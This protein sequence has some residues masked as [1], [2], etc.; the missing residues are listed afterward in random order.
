MVSP[1]GPEPSSSA[2]ILQGGCESIVSFFGLRKGLTEIASRKYMV[3][4]GR[5]H[6]K[7]C[8]QNT[9]KPLGSN[10]SGSANGVRLPQAPHLTFCRASH[11]GLPGVV[12]RRKRNSESTPSAAA[13]RPSGRPHRCEEIGNRSPKARRRDQG[14]DGRRRLPRHSS[15]LRRTR[16]CGRL[17]GRSSFEPFKS[18][19]AR[20]K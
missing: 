15:T 7:P 12:T 1:L 13:S 9:V 11:V 8:C 6:G 4:I 10:P 3:A 16:T 17:V 19:E 2:K 5:L 18:R 20:R 14:H